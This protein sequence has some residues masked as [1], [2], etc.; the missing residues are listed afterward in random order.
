M[1]SLGV[2]L[3]KLKKC[4]KIERKIKMHEGQ[5][6]YIGCKTFVVTSGR[7]I[8]DYRLVPDW[9]SNILPYTELIINEGESSYYFGPVVDNGNYNLINLS[10]LFSSN[11]KDKSLTEL[12]DI[13]KFVHH[14]LKKDGY[15]SKTRDFK[16]MGIIWGQIFDDIEEGIVGTFTN[17]EMID[18]L[19]D[20]EITIIADMIREQID[21]DQKAGRKKCA[22]NIPPRFRKKCGHK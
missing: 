3:Q 5:E 7:L 6:C 4:L 22:N 9:N 11:L 2:R 16:E 17:K 8:Y 10:I 14:I 20:M 21:N 12:K 13:S 1:A 18:I 19:V 15:C